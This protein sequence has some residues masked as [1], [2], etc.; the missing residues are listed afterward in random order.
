MNFIEKLNKKNIK[1][2]SD[3][4]IMAWLVYEKRATIRNTTILNKRLGNILSKVMDKIRNK[5][6]L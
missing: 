3:L 1:K 2:Y 5:E 6:N 4:E